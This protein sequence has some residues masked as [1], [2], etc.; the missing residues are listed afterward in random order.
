MLIKI[1]MEKL[2]SMM[3]LSH[4]ELMKTMERCFKAAGIK[5]AHSQGFNPRPQMSFALPLAVGVEAKKM[6]L[7]VELDQEEVDFSSLALPRG[8]R[9]VDYKRSEKGPS[10]M[11][12]VARAEYLIQ[13]DLDKL[14][15]L[16]ADEP[17]AYQKKNKRSRIKKREARDYILS[18]S[19][20]E[21]G[22]R[23]LLRA[24]SEANIKPTDLLEAL[25]EDKDQVHSYEICLLDIYD[26]EGRSLWL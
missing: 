17:L 6:I 2:D 12:R 20:E 22:Y 15:R 13:G 18:S 9:I 26:D 11:S 21:E 19:K 23:F 1:W 16:E 8:L 4:L 25:L 5:M 3:F 24:G 7:E 14:A 10:L